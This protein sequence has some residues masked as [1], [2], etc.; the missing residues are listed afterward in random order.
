MKKNNIVYV[1][2][3]ADLVH[4]GHVNIIKV[5]RLYGEVVVGLLTDRAILSYKRKP[6]MT[7]KQRKFVIENFKGVKKVIQQATHDYSSNLIK[8]KPQYVVHG[9][10]WKKGPQKQI[11][12]KVIKVL[13]EWNG[14]LI[15]V[16][17][18]KGISTTKIL[19]KLKKE[20]TKRKV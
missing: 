4:H 9:D 2:F 1:G 17:Y 5:A 11:R 15:E 7:Y 16:P 8:T 12:K 10:D 18:T 13:S 6:F 19:S 20:L 14:E 3:A